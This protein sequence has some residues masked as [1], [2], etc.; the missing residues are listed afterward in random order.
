MN[1]ILSDVEQ[2][3]FGEFTLRMDGIL[4]YQDKET[5]LPPKELGVLILLLNSAGVL[6]SK[7]EILEKVWGGDAVAEES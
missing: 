3:I 2:Y 5:S 6:I 7:D 1:K 4:Y